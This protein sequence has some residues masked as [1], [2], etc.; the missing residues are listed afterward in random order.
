MFNL[1]RLKMGHFMLFSNSLITV[2]VKAVVA[3]QCSQC[4]KSDGVREENLSACINPNLPH[5]K[6]LQ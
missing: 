6:V 5:G 4:T 2:V 3:A 1:I